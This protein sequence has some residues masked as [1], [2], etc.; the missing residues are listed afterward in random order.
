[1]HPKAL[2]N[3]ATLEPQ[4]PQCLEQHIPGGFDK[5]VLRLIKVY[6]ESKVFSN[7]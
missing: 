3:V 6:Q 2:T 5:Y 1:M 4:I 7:M